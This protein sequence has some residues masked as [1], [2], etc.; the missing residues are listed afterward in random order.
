MR[1]H[2]EI[3][4]VVL[5]SLY[6]AFRNTLIIAWLQITSKY[7]NGLTE[8]LLKDKKYKTNVACRKILDTCFEAWCLFLQIDVNGHS[9]EHGARFS[10]L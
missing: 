5:T 9:L 6:S 10:V 4:V 7:L 8:D 3:S 2:C 1:V